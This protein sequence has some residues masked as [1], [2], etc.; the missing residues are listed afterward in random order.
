MSIVKDKIVQVLQPK[1]I[2]PIINIIVDYAIDKNTIGK[3]L[4]KQQKDKNLRNICDN[5]RD[6]ENEISENCMKKASIGKYSYCYKFETS[7][8][9]E[10]AKKWF[11]VHFNKPETSQITGLM[12]K[13]GFGEN[14]TFY[15][16]QGYNYPNT[17][18]E[19]LYKIAKDNEYIAKYSTVC[20]LKGLLGYYQRNDNL[21]KLFQP[22]DFYQPFVDE[23]NTYCLSEQFLVLL[24]EQD[25][26]LDLKNNEIQII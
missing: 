16:H 5:W 26:V 25:I 7:Y 11:A 20:M 12:Y 8:D 14:M 2:G 18:G 23:T 9:F 24:K 10:L 4:L 15:W 3:Q 6:Y 1:I 17:L 13:E 19:I 22:Y 21:V